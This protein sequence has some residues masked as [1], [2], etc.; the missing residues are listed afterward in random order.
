[1]A[2]PFEEVSGALLKAGSFLLGIGKRAEQLFTREKALAPEAVQATI[3]V[4][5]DLESFIALSAP[6]AG[7]EGLNFAAD[8]AA[9]AAFL[10]LVADSKAFVSVAEQA[11]KAAA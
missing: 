9:Y 8:S 4:F 1:M 3:T 6:A 2:N 7:A 10:K 5:S 11:I